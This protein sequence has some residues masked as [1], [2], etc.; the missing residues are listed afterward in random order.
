M[1]N[2]VVAA[3]LALCLSGCAK[4]ELSV[5]TEGFTVEDLASYKVNTPDHRRFCP[6]IGQR[7]II[8]WFLDDC[9]PDATLV[10][11]QIRYRNREEELL[12]IP[13]GS[14]TG[15]YIYE[16]ADQDYLC[17][18]GMLAYQV[19]AWQGDCLCATTCHHLWTELVEVGEDS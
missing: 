2:Y 5:T 13:V 9:C 1:R 3:I 7:L 17:R 8:R 15:C 10:T 12:E 6:S 11:V 19:Q 18:G 16:I 14:S 4:S